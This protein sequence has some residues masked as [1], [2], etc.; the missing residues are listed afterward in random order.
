VNDL[1]SSNRL[2]L[3]CYSAA[4][5]LLCNST[6]LA[7]DKMTY[8]ISNVNIAHALDEL[9]GKVVRLLSVLFNHFPDAHLRSTNITRTIDLLTRLRKAPEGIPNVGDVAD[10]LNDILTFNGGNTPSTSMAPAPSASM[11]NPVAAPPRPAQQAHR[12]TNPYYEPQAPQE[13]L[14]PQAPQA[15]PAYYGAPQAQAYYGAPQ[16]QAPQ[17]YYGAPQAMH[18]PVQP[19]MSQS[20]AT[21]LISQS[22]AT[23]PQAPRVN[24]H[25]QMDPTKCQAMVIDKTTRQQRQCKNKLG[26]C[27]SHRQ[28]A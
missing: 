16:A 28:A 24:G 11:S 6:Y 26:S 21:S 20:A 7:C 10:E 15:P 12:V 13:P 18:Y 8:T 14:A 25:I 27:G 1:Q 4:T 19:A 17:P 2:L 22:A 3:C 23:Q 9:L 5:L